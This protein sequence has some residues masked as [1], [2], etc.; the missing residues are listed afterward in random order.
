MATENERA[1][2][3]NI[4]IYDTDGRISVDVLIQDETVWLNQEQIAILFG[5]GRS[6]IAEHIQNIFK[7]KELDEKMVCRDFR[8]TTK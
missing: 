6:T 4:L 3:Q 5:K 8:H 2:H 1:I 7:D